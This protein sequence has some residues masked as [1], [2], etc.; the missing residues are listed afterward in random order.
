MSNFLSR[1]FTTKL[2]PPST[3]LSPFAPYLGAA[4]AAIE[5]G[6]FEQALDAYRNGLELARQQGDRRAQHLLTS[7][8]GTDF[9]KMRQYG[10]ARVFFQIALQ[11]A[12]QIDDPAL[13]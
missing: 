6:N 5:R 8:M 4:Q 3:P 7:G 2:E 1:L 9:Y 12:K 10:Q 13:I 11:L